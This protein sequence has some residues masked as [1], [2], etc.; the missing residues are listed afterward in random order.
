V[1]ESKNHDGETL[2]EALDRVSDNFEDPFD[3]HRNSRGRYGWAD[4]LAGHAVVN[5]FVTW[6]REQP[7]TAGHVWFWQTL[8]TLALL[9]VWSVA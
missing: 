9:L 2:A 5:V 3:E 8:G 6:C 7:R 1:T 4:T